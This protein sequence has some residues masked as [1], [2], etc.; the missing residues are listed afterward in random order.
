MKKIIIA[1][2]SLILLFTMVSCSGKNNEIILDGE[3]LEFK[4][5]GYRD[6]NGKTSIYDEK[7]LFERAKDTS[8]V[9]LVVSS[10]FTHAYYFVRYVSNTLNGAENESYT[11]RYIDYS[12]NGKMIGYSQ[13]TFTKVKNGD[14]VS[15]ETNY[16]YYLMQ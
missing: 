5:F 3:L 16:V 7:E 9:L 12:F 14:N 6:D 11:Y 13:I 15:Y 10:N 8:S 1:V 2:L 4:E